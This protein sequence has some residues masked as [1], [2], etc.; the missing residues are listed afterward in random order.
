MCGSSSD[1]LVPQYRVQ[2]IVDRVDIKI[3]PVIILSDAVE[4]KKN[5][6]KWVFQRD[7]DLKH[8]SERAASSFHASEIKAEGLRVQCLHLHS[9]EDMWASH[10]KCCF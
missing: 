5:A 9:T 8:T 4:K 1:I 10:H 7:K 6:S 3:L 2:W